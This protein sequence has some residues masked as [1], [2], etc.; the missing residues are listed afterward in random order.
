MAI[1]PYFNPISYENEIFITGDVFASN[2]AY[3][4]YQYVTAIYPIANK[5]T[6][7]SIGTGSK[8]QG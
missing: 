1:P 3:F 8:A 6:I 7:V 2:P 5:T 4:A